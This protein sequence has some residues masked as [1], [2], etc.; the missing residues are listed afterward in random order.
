MVLTVTNYKVRVKNIMFKPYTESIF[1]GS[2][3]YIK[4]QSE[5]KYVFVTH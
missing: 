5:R 4:G 2:G 3:A 1:K